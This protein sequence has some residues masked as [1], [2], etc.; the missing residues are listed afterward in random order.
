VRP[1]FGGQ[2]K[3]LF[4]RRA[5]EIAGQ[6]QL[7]GSHGSIFS[8]PGDDSATAREKEVSFSVSDRDRFR[9]VLDVG[10]AVG[11]EAVSGGVTVEQRS[12]RDP[13]LGEYG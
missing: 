11:V 1:S 3:W 10:L 9:G 5:T 4:V 2:I 6:G 8:H 7:N 12:E 13:K